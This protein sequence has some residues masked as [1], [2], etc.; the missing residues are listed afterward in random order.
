MYFKET[1]VRAKPDEDIDLSGGDGHL[2]EIADESGM[3]WE[4][5]HSNQTISTINGIKDVH[6]Y[7]DENGSIFASWKAWRRGD[8]EASA[9][10]RD[11]AIRNFLRRYHPR[12]KKGAVAF[13]PQC[14]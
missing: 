7:Y 2:R 8:G 3:D 10:S 11:E 13:T 5:C 9:A 14:E 12:P 4:T 1:D 6:V